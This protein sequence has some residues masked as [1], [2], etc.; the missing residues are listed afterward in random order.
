M[1]FYL[2][3]FKFQPSECIHSREEKYFVSMYIKYIYYHWLYDNL[4]KYPC[5]L[6][7]IYFINWF[8]IEN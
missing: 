6:N 7:L 4:I 8:T 2:I 5:L 3:F 1:I